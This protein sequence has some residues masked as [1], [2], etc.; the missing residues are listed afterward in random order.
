MNE[1]IQGKKNARFVA[2]Q[3]L[4]CFE[5]GQKY[6]QIEKK[7][8]VAQ[9][10]IKEILKSKNNKNNKYTLE[11]DF[12]LFII[13]NAIEEQKYNKDIISMKIKNN[14]S[15]ERI[16]L[17]TLCII[18]LAIV[19]MRFIPDTEIKII[20]DEYVKITKFFIGE[21]SAISFVNGILDAISNIIKR[22]N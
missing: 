12:L 10:T 20:I 6:L 8:F 5:F 14:W 11:K 19:E 1:K 13:N 17:L 2:A 7:D 9:E 4:Y 16:D 15:L 22:D 3:A 21:T 18:Q